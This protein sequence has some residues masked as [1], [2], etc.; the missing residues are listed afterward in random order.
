MST[1][2][3][4]W[5]DVT[6]EC[7][8]C[9]DMFDCEIQLYTTRE[10]ALVKALVRSLITGCHHCGADDLAITVSNEYNTAEEL[11]Q[12]R[13]NENKWIFLYRRRND[14]KDIF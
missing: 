13:V 8:V 6:V 11:K 3:D 14:K 4:H 9:H 1:Y 2:K 10:V 7:N 5:Y 12:L